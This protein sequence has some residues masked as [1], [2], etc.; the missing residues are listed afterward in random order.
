MSNQDASSGS[1]LTHAFTLLQQ[2]EGAAAER[3]VRAILQAQPQHAGAAT[4]LALAC[5]QQGRPQDAL[6]IFDRLCVLEP[7]EPTHWANLANCMCEMGRD[8]DALIPMQQAFKLGANDPG[9]YFA[10]ARTLIAHRRLPEALQAI[11]AAIRHQ[12]FDADLRLTRARILTSLDRWP[13]ANAEIE[14]LARLPMSAAQRAEAGHV[15]LQTGLYADAERLFAMALQ[16]DPELLDARIGLALT[17][18]RTNQVPAAEQTALLL[19]EITMDSRLQ[20]KI[21]QL[22]ARLAQRGGDAATARDYLQMLLDPPPSDP[23][24]AAALAFDLAQAEASLGAIPATMIA[25]QTAHQAKRAQVSTTHPELL[26][27]DSLLGLLERPAPA[28]GPLRTPADGLTDPVFLVGFP[29]SGTT[30]LEQLLDAHEGLVSFDEQPF[31]Q[32][33]INRLAQAGKPYPESLADLDVDVIGGLRQAY[34]AEVTKVTAGRAGGAGGA[35]PRAVDK[36]P[37]NLARIPFIDTVFPKAHILFAVRHPCDVVLSCY[38]QNFR[39]P[40]LALSF[41][42][43]LSTAQMYDRVMGYVF[44]DLAQIRTPIHRVRYEDLVADVQTEGKRI[45]QFLGLPWDDELLRFTE[46][47]REKRSISTPSYSQVVQAVNSRAVGKWQAYGAYFDDA[48]MA[49]LRPWI[50]AFGYPE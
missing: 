36:N 19:P 12:G 35:L 44:G 47:A 15:L 13:D 17:Q 45:F 27:Q 32:R 26:R 38:Q 49:C 28:R 2:G 33:L 37:L 21:W 25:L 7:N 1:V 39:A 16:Q 48:V 41:E 20:Q 34:F 6:P 30:L 5:L 40:A 11:D 42:T 23:S 18:E 29:R 10:Y 50:E 4:V 43:L 31:L 3:L 22:R 9:S 14:L 46:R 24:L 8:A